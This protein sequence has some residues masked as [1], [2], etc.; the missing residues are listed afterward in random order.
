MAWD[1]SLEIWGPTVE[2]GIATE[3]PFTITVENIVSNAVAS[4]DLGKIQMGFS[5]DGDITV[6]DQIGV[7]S[8]T[9]AGTFEGQLLDVTSFSY[10]GTTI[11]GTTT[12]KAEFTYVDNGEGVSCDYFLL[13]LPSNW[14]RVFDREG[15][16][17]DV[18]IALLVDGASGGTLSESKEASGTTL[19][20]ALGAEKSFKA[21]ESYSV[22][23]KDLMTPDNAINMEF[24]SM[25]FSIGKSD[26]GGVAY[27]QDGLSL[28]EAGRKP[29]H[30]GPEGQEV[31]AFRDNMIQITRGTFSGEVCF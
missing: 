9:D 31:A 23:I 18:T 10:D 26:T 21:G 13:E 8:E 29:K 5:Q 15:S 28:R 19:R 22:E 12:I 20:V 2:G 1:W 25:V 6:F 14:G 4:A 11:R 30:D 3:D 7:D 24:A 17:G 16:V 27:S